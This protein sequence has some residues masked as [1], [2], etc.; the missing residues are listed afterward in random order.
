MPASRFRTPPREVEAIQWQGAANC[1]EVHAFC[2]LPHPEDTSC[3][4][5]HLRGAEVTIY[6]G[7]WLIRYPSGAVAVMSPQEFAGQYEP[8][9]ADDSTS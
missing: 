3:K 1:A 6:P 7:D 5:L 9:P 2:G 4:D 8:V